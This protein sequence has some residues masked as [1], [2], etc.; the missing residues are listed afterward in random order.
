MTGVFDLAGWSPRL[1]L[2]GNPRFIQVSA[3]DAEQM[4]TA[5]PNFLSAKMRK[6]V[7]A[8]YWD[9]RYS[10]EPFLL[11]PVREIGVNQHATANSE[12]Y[13]VL[14]R[15]VVAAVD[16]YGLQPGP[17]RWVTHAV[18]T[19][20]DVHDALVAEA[21]TATFL[22][23]DPEVGKPPRVLSVWA[24]VYSDGKGL[25]EVRRFRLNSTQRHNPIDND[26]WQSVAAFIVATSGDPKMTRIRVVEVGLTQGDYKVVFDDDPDAAKRHYAT[27]H[28]ATLGVAIDQEGYSPGRNCADCKLVGICPAQVSLDGSLGQP[29]PGIGTRSV[30]ASDLDTYLRCPARWL[31][32]RALHLPQENEAGGAAARG[33]LVHSWLE[34]AHTRAIKCT[35]AD[36]PDQ[37]DQEGSFG[38]SRDDY[39][40]ALPYLRAHLPHCPLGPSVR[41]VQL[42]S[43]LYG[44]DRPADV[45]IAAKPDAI[46]LEEDVLLVRETKTTGSTLPVDATEAYD[47]WPVVSWLISLLASG[48]IDKLNA[49]KAVVELE[50]L[51][52]EG[53]ST[54]GWDLDESAIVRMAQSDVSVRAEGWHNDS[55]WTTTPGPHCEYCPVRRW[56]PDSDRADS[57]VEPGAL[58]HHDDEPTGVVEDPPPF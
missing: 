11:R 8:R 38:L 24:P 55:Q 21:G 45:V 56:C 7:R 10:P 48:Y 20:L 49:N 52:P 50:V 36:L 27:S 39:K 51:T 37:V 35:D 43:P 4:G 19:Y 9:R 23:F 12:P 58:H 47:R 57:M 31:M 28:R 32:E 26:R 53:G 2:V 46:L 44:Y 22:D 14:H 34:V 30:S 25:R 18:E 33:R 17:A 3:S 1:E 15:S 13:E 54:Y 41:V 40:L 6:G 5:C 16:T 29:G 42:D